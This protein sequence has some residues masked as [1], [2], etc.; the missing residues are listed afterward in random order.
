MTY[1]RQS[2]FKREDGLVKRNFRIPAGSD[3]GEQSDKARYAKHAR[4]ALQRQTH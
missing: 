2:K 1:G 4:F 3:N